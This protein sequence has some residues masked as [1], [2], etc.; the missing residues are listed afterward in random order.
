MRAN[1]QKRVV[2]VTYTKPH[3]NR[4]RLIG[5]AACAKHYRGA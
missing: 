1:P 3:R 4:R 2:S 5:P